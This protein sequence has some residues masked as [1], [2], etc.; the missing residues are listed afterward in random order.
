MTRAES[1]GDSRSSVGLRELDVEVVGDHPALPGQDLGVVV[2][3]ALEGGGDLDG[4]DGAAERAGEGPG[5]QLP[6]AAARTSAGRSRHTPLRPVVAFPVVSPVPALVGRGPSLVGLPPI[7][8]GCERRSDSA[9]AESDAGHGSATGRPRVDAPVWG[10]PRPG[11]ALAGFWREWRNRQTRTVQVRVS[12]RTWGFNSPLA[13]QQ[14][15]LLR[16][17]DGPCHRGST[18]FAASD[19]RRSLRDR[20]RRLRRP[21]SRCERGHWRL[22]P[23]PRA[24]ADPP[25]PFRPPG[26]SG[27]TRRRSTGP[28]SDV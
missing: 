6:R 14:I 23:S 3:L 20:A 13:H 19:V 25:Q 27:C 18:G 12:E 10:A 9:E 22:L 28:R 7:V 24:V 2:A 1:Y 16:E 21:R 8:S 5:D 11:I 4:L 26:R 15:S 17:H